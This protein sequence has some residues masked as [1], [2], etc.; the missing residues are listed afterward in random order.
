MSSTTETGPRNTPFEKLHERF[1]GQMV[2]YAGW[3][4][5]LRFGSV[6]EEHRAVRA[7]GGLFDVSHMGRLRFMGPDACRFLDRVC[8]RQIH[9]MSEG[10]CRYSLVCN[11]QG[12]CRDDVLVYRMESESYLM[13]CNAA[14]RDKLIA[15]FAEHSPD[16]DVSIDDQTLATA[17]C[18]I[19]GPRVMDLIGGV[20]REIPALKR[21]RFTIKDLMVIKVIVS[22]TGYT[23]EDGVEVIL[24]AKMATPAL[25]MFLKDFGENDSMVRP[26]GL[27]ARDTLRLEAAMPLYGHELTED[28][29][30]LSAG[31]GFAVKLD[32]GVEHPEVGGFI[33]QQAL[34]EVA[35]R[36]PARRLVGLLPE[37]RRS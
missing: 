28:I 36:G 3:N 9:G 15:H 6:I 33:G 5:P 23:G 20:S 22:R 35:D 18:A 24:D 25:E 19:Q 30:P 37:G 11:E 17:M 29:D 10:Q 1:G 16:F 8:T 4:L 14:N 13:V 26:C 31:L 27:A 12:G 21:F 34:Q 7:S 2:D 32:K